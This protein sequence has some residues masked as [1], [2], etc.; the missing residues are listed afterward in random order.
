MFLPHFPVTSHQTQKWAVHLITQLLINLMLIEMVFVIFEWMFQG[1]ISFNLMLLL[2]LLN[3][4][5]KSR[6]KLVYFF[7][8]VNI[9]ASLVRLHGYQLFVRL[10]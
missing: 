8:I 1:I 3:S 9:R 5:S 7:L 6:L 2:L 10:S 4:V